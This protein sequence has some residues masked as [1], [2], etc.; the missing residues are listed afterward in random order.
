MK[1]KV[2]ILI[3]KDQH[4]E[5]SDIK[6]RLQSLEYK[7]AGIAATLKE[8][9]SLAEEKKPNLVLIDSR[10]SGKYGSKEIGRK[11]KEKYNLPV[12]FIT[13][14]VNLASLLQMKETKPFDFITIP[15]KNIELMGVIETALHKYKI[16][17]KLRE[18]EEKYHLLADNTKD[19]IWT[20]D[21]KENINFENAKPTFVSPSIEE[22]TG[23]T[24]QEISNQKLIEILTSE[25]MQLVKETL[26]DALRNERTE[27]ERVGR[28]LE[29]EHY[30][31]DG[32][33]VWLESN[34]SFLRD[35]NKNPVGII[36]VSR[37]INKRKQ[38]EENLK[39]S[40]KNSR[41][42]LNA[43]H[44]LVFLIDTT[45]ILIDTNQ[46]LILDRPKQE[47]IGKNYF[48]LI[49]ES[50]AKKR[51]AKVDKVVQTGK[52]VSY[53][54]QRAG[55]YFDSNLYPIFDKNKNVI[56]IAVFAKDITSQKKAD[57]KIHRL[58]KEKE[59][60]L[61]E[62]HHRIKNNM[63]IL[64]SIFSLQANATENSE[65]KG[66][67]NI[68]MNRIALMSKIYEQ[69]YKRPNIQNVEIRSVVRDL[70]IEI[71]ET[72]ESPQKCAISIE[73]DVDKITVSVKQSFPIGIII[74]ELVTNVYKY[75]FPDRKNGIINISVKES[76]AKA[77]QI[78]VRD[79]GIG[80]PEELIRNK[81]YGFGLQLVSIFSKQYEG[82][83]DI[84]RDKGT[85]VKVRMEK[86][87]YKS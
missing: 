31:K 86:E 58:L 85:V 34:M 46:N 28:T 44:D 10:F 20:L 73:I 61:K 74:N 67:L 75:A 45:G 87:G 53:Q 12:V 52:A 47:M 64:K 11:L 62:V 38:I 84:K 13:N 3:V 70:V 83:L 37:D 43:T 65:A 54:D 66:I 63:N 71:Q 30:C 17:R 81:S 68:A 27:Q 26:I 35:K 77:L 18:S 82:Q 32:S 9:F 49:P 50:I 6:N 76:N 19:I 33:S 24:P 23:Y 29:L 57:K 79:N 55:K 1:D 59:L 16:E 36:G 60:L 48:E 2:T 56:Q 22:V 7:V 39:R 69:L 4:I 72:Y 78:R 15:F 80:I 21:L 51:K 41:T 25:S 40:E 14:Q 5:G 42:L 8:A